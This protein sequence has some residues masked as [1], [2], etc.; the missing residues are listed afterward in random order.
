MNPLLSIKGTIISGF[1]LSQLD[2]QIFIIQKFFFGD[3]V[4]PFII[5]LSLL[6]KILFYFI[7]KCSI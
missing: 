6:I 5:S 2:I 3:I 4:I 1:V 7:V